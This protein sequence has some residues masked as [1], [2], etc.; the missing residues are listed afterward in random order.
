MGKNYVLKS[1]KSAKE[2]LSGYP[3]G[4]GHTGFMLWGESGSE[5]LSFNH[6]ELFRKKI[7]KDIK[8]A[9]IIPEIRRLTLM[10]DSKSAEA[11]FNEAAS[12]C[13][14][15]CNPYQTFCELK[16]DFEAENITDYCRTLDLKKGKRS[17]FLTVL[18]TLSVV[19]VNY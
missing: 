16:L 7:K 15:Y 17:R 1:S 12:D 8:T 19:F 10:G 11:L 3:C 14:P 4:N 18:F 9:H 6:E 5:T 13:D 2:W